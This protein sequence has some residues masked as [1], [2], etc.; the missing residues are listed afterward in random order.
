MTNPNGARIGSDKAADGERRPL[1][2]SKFLPTLRH[3]FRNPIFPQYLGR[4]RWVSRIAPELQGLVLDIGCGHRPFDEWYSGARRLVSVDYTTTS[5]V[6]KGLPP[7]AWAEGTALPFGD[8]VFDNA[9]CWEVIEHLPN[10]EELL[11]EARRVL[12]PGGRLLLST[13]LT[14]P[15]HGMPHDY[16][17]W[18]MNGLRVFAEKNGFFVRDIFPTNGFILVTGQFLSLC[19][20]EHIAR[21]NRIVEFLLRPFFGTIGLLSIL[22][23]EL[24]GRDVS[25]ISYFADLERGNE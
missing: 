10:P 11:Q 16:Y 6:F 1:P 19:L 23:D 4:L 18:T 21:G 3:A 7:D 9:T 15:L 5:V 22:L 2:L 25:S 14:W 12:K 24:V 13:P 20:V 17:R 8:G